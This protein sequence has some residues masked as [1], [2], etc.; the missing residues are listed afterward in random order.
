VKFSTRVR[1]QIKNRSKGQ[2]EVCGMRLMIYEAQIHHR[3]PRGMGGSKSA[4]TGS[5]S[6]GLHVHMKCH[7]RIE[8]NRINAMDNGYLMYQTQEPSEVP[9]R[10]WYG[11]HLLNEDGT[12]TAIQRESGGG[13]ASLPAG[14][15]VVKDVETSVHSEKVQWVSDTIPM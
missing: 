10:L 2:C 14:V 11:W 13:E 12:V 8:S 4:A 9:A 3:R 15:Q 6:N 7:E 5:V 1:E